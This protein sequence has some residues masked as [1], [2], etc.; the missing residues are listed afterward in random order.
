MRTG[1]SFRNTKSR[2]KVKTSLQLDGFAHCAI[3]WIMNLPITYSKAVDALNYLR[4]ERKIMMRVNDFTAGSIFQ[5]KSYGAV[6]IIEY[7]G[8]NDVEVKF[9]D[10]GTIHTFIAA[11]IRAGTI[12]D[13]EKPTVIGVGY[14]GIGNHRAKVGGKNTQAYD[15]WHHMLRRCY[16]NDYQKKYPTYIGCEVASEWHNFQN[17]AGWFYENYPRDGEHYD[18]DKDIK[19]KGNKKYSPSTCIFATKKDNYSEAHAKDFSFISPNGDV[20]NITNLRQFCDGNESLR[21]AL[22]AVHTGAR[23]SH[24]GWTKAST[25][26]F[27]LPSDRE[28]ENE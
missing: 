20:V 11:N 22:N 17:F 18:L 12:K 15:R 1:T 26:S 25:G 6:Q 23:K 24:K 5:T 27:D 3:M 28:E 19:I 10:T 8:T 13:P 16:C 7:R 4:I 21:K 9:L 14:I 2:R